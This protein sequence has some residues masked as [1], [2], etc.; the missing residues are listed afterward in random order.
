M[1]SVR[2]IAALHKRFVARARY[3]RTH[4]PFRRALAPVIANWNTAY[5]MF[6]ISKHAFP[7]DYDPDVWPYPPALAT[8]IEDWS[9]LP[10][11]SRTGPHKT[12]TAVATARWNSSLLDLARQWWPATY[13]PAW[14]WSHKHPAAP[15]VGAC[16]IWGPQWAAEE[17]WVAQAPLPVWG[18]PF[19]P[20]D[21]DKH[22]WVVRERVRHDTFVQRLRDVLAGG[23][24][25]TADL[26]ETLDLE[27]LQAS[28]EMTQEGGSSDPAAPY[29]VAPLFPGM[30]S[31]DWRAAEAGVRQQVACT[32]EVLSDHARRLADEG[33]NTRQI[34]GL[35]GISRQKV[36]RM[37][38]AA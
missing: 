15:F 4:P 10:S 7:S 36:A 20:L 5:P 32:D 27:A 19:D 22:P 29:L 14:F 28:V 9:R 11:V 31:P 34:A 12:V 1:A 6:A 17:E 30:A 26:L 25:I 35:L 3:L 37:I 16:L 38:H 33:K 23:K 8:A 21:P 2:P 18:L 13:Y 24:A